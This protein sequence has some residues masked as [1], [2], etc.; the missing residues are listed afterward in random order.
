MHEETRQLIEA[1]GDLKQESNYFKDYM[2]PIVSA[3]FSSLLGAAIAYFT[4]KWQA[5]IQIEKEKL[6]ITNKWIL[7]AEEAR[8]N[9]LAI[10]DNYHGQLDDNPFQRAALIPT[11]L[12]YDDPLSV[13]YHELSFIVPSGSSADGEYPKWSQIPII[14]TMFGNYN[15]TLSMWKQR[16][17]LNEEFKHGLFAAHG[18]AV[19]NGFSIKHAIDAVGQPFLIKFIDLTERLVKLTDDLV[20]EMDDFLENFPKYAKTR[21]RCKKIKSYGSV[22]TYSNNDNKALLDRLK[23]SPEADF[24]NLESLFGEKSEDIKKRHQTGYE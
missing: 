13:E 21:I 10:K 15:Q 1:I 2:F 20:V 24:S 16:N 5:R 12:L 11:I 22:L 9:L 4:L 8:S 7:V 17:T 19:V 6:D 14:R 23:K 18:D 3:F